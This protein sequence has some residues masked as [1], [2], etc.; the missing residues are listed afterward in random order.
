MQ[1]SNDESKTVNS[2]GILSSNLNLMPAGILSSFT[3]GNTVV[4]ATGLAKKILE[5]P[6][7]DREVVVVQELYHNQARKIFIQ[8][9]VKEG[10]TYYEG[11]KAHCVAGYKYHSGQGVFVNTSVVNVIDNRKLCFAKY[12]VHGTGPL[13]TSVPK[14]AIHLILSK[15]GI[16]K[17]IDLI[18]I[19]LQSEIM[20]CGWDIIN[21]ATGKRSLSEARSSLTWNRAAI[22][23]EQ[24][25]NLLTNL[26]S[27]GDR[28][29]FVGDYNVCYSS[30]EFQRV[31]QILDAKPIDDKEHITIGAEGNTS[32]YPVCWKI[33]TA[34]WGGGQLDHMLVRAGISRTKST[35]KVLAMKNIESLTDHEAIISRI[36]LV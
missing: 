7:D 5:Q 18:A 35:F 23:R 2:I 6:S 31:K 8:L 3:T 1:S 4:R 27:M 13:E 26:W 15:V 17:P 34:I 29:V 24:Q 22:V 10:Y 21:A 20:V 28:T 14:C 16:S 30:T 25:L 9:M 32:H 33:G 36:A 19:H 11:T 12:D